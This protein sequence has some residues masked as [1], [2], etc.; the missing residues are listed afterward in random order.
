MVQ[1]ARSTASPSDLII[2]LGKPKRDPYGGAHVQHGLK[3]KF[4]VYIMISGKLCKLTIIFCSTKTQST[5]VIN[6]LG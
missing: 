2:D 3:R 1:S 6:D 4:V 5:C